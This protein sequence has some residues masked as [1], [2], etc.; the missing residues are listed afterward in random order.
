MPIQHSPPARKTRSHAGTEA[1]LTTTPR[2]TLHGTPAVSQ[3]RTHVDRGPNVEGAAPS[4]KEGR[5]ARRSSSFSGVVGGLPGTSRTIFKGPGE[6]G[7]EEEENSVQA[8]GS[9]GTEGVL[10]PVEAPQGTG[11]PNLAQSNQ[12]VPHKSEPSL[13]AIMQKMT[14]IMDNLHDASSTEASRPPAFKTPSMKAPKCFDGT[15]PFNVR[16][17]IQYCQLNIHN[18]PVNFS[19]DRKMVLYSTS[20]LIVRVAKWIEPYVSNLTNQDPNYLLN[21][22]KSF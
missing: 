13:L 22:W 8:E 3:L 14:L 17:F 5:V 4:T 9:D 15:E 2:D 11:G 19:Q 18:D 21:S 10:A 1:V 16:S 7:A 6:D 12:P 20:F